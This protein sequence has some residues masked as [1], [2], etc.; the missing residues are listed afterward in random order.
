MP[1]VT[2]ICKNCGKPYEACRTL[3][4][5]SSKVFRWQDVACSPECGEAYLAAVI[6]SRITQLADEATKQETQEAEPPVEESFAA[7]APEKEQSSKQRSRRSKKS[8]ES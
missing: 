4:P 2:K 6:A 7:E 5:R 1:T 8:D 3:K